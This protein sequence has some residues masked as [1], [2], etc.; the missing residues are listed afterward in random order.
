MQPELKQRLTAGTTW[1]RGLYIVI[2]AVIFGVTEVVLWAV[3]VFQFLLA[4]FRGEANA[5]LLTFCLSLAAF[6]YQMVAFMTF[7]SDE[8]P[9]PFGPWPKGAAPGGAQNAGSESNH[10]E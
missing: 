6:I 3:V 5:R 7:S 1:M 10:R 4:L 2:F 9:F 8:K